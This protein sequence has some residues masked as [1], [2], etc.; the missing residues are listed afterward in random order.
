M[1]GNVANVLPGHFSEV[2]LQ[3]MRETAARARE[4][5]E[6]GLDA[7]FQLAD[8]AG[9]RA[10]YFAT[11]GTL[12]H[13]CHASTSGARFALLPATDAA[14]AA[15]IVFCARYALM[16][17][18]VAAQLADDAAASE[19]ARALLQQLAGWLRERETTPP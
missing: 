19:R 17:L 5:R 14:L 15:T 10:E 2:T 12:S 6:G 11:Y 13:P 9:L 1:I 18:D 16:L 3:T 8:A 7:L 4:Q